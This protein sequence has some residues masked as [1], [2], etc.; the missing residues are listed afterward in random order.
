MKPGHEATRALVILVVGAL[1]LA[2]VAVGYFSHTLAAGPVDRDPIILGIPL[3]LSSAPVWVGLDRGFFERHGLNVTLREYDTG[4][5]AATGVQLGEANSLGRVRLVQK[6]FG[7]GTLLGI[8]S[9]ARSELRYLVGRRD[10]GVA[11][12][13]DLFGK[14]VGV[15]RRTISEFYLSRFVTLHGQNL[16]GVT[17]VDLSRSDGVEALCNGSVSAVVTA[18]PYLSAIRGRLGDGAS[19]LPVQSSQYTYTVVVGRDA[20]IAG[21]PAET[22]PVPAGRRRGRR[23]DIGPPGRR[24]ADP[25]GPPGHGRPAAGRGVAPAPVLSLARPV[26]HPRHGG[27]GTL[28]DQEQPDRCRDR[29]GLPEVSLDRQ[30]RAREPGVGEARRVTCRPVDRCPGIAETVTPA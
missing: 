11:N 15:P 26:A 30:P 17:L 16:D 13:S 20:W 7:N 18:E 2:G 4:L 1:A 12:V 28:D 3:L 23:L 27:R 14:R 25:A 19:V 5:S 9:V 6:A 29:A 22:R 10:H 24:K 21:H 8:G